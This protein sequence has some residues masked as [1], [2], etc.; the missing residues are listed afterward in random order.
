MVT[1]EFVIIG[2]LPKLAADLSVTI[3]QASLLATIFA[4][5]VAIAAS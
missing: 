3:A 4:F 1:T 5:Y 2:D